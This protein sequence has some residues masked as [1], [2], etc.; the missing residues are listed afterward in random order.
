MTTRQP[1]PLTRRTLLKGSAALPLVALASG[2][3]PALAATRST[4]EPAPALVAGN[5]AFALDLYAELRAAGSGNLLF[6]P[7]SISQALAMT[8]AGADGE[9][10][11]QM[12]ATLGFPADQPAVNAAFAA[13][14]ADLIARGSGGE[15][16]GALR[17][18]NA[19]W[20]EQTYPFSEAYSAEIERSYGA[21]LQETDFAGAPEAAREE[22]NAWVAEQTEDRIQD[23]VPPGVI[24][25]LTRLVLANAIYFYG[26]W[27][28][29]FEPSDTE[30]D[31]FN[32]LDGGT[33]TVP[34]MSQQETFPYAAGDGWQAIELPYEQEGFAMTILLPDEGT[35]DAF[36]EGLDAA[37][38]DA[39]L[40]QL[41]WTDVVLHLPKFEFTFG[42]SL[43]DALKAMGMT[44]AFDPDL[45]DF[46]GMVDGTPP[47]QLSIGNVLHKAFISVDEEG[48]EAAAATAV[49]V[50]ATSAAPPEDPLE[51]WVD[52]PFL[53]AIR[54]TVTGTLLFL[55]RVLDP[56]A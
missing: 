6:S 23:I 28:D 41:D 21:G 13:L 34:F 8:W 14:N 53:F 27:R 42:E 45:A 22:I 3:M 46:S 9:T 29:T 11:A 20:G 51:V 7:Y 43:A 24:T 49:I 44:D 5:T 26:P 2:H 54:D 33:V 35:Y 47:E 50:G 10:A 40:G 12:V 4:P 56:S 38:L 36:E 16:E 32:L 31:T 17:V 55:G 52:R 48:T 30:D 18:A 25:E 1:H 37:T 19:L 39:A 15:G